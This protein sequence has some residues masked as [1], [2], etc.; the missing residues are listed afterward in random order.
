MWAERSV[1]LQQ[2]SQ[3]P[4]AWGQE[5]EAPLPRLEVYILFTFSTFAV[6]KPALANY[7][8]PGVVD[9][10]ALSHITQTSL[11]MLLNC[12]CLVPFPINQQAVDLENVKCSSFFVWQ[13][14]VNGMTVLFGLSLLSC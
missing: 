4:G 9:W 1:P 11:R 2:E 6:A 12:L 8:F 13:S 7:L 14:C 5:G 10:Q 3:E